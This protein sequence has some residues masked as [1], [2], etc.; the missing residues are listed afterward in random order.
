[1]LEKWDERYLKQWWE[2]Q[3]IDTPEE[4]AE[5][6]RLAKE[7]SCNI[8][9]WL[10]ISEIWPEKQDMDTEHTSYGYLHFHKPH[11]GD[12][13]RVIKGRFYHW[14]NCG[15]RFFEKYNQAEFEGKIHMERYTNLQ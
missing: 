10:I 6:C 11:K 3:K 4:Q 14:L 5:F 12:Q 7:L 13:A 1:M 2:F 8:T 9:P 15:V